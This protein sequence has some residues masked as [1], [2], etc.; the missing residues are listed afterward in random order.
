MMMGQLSHDPSFQESVTA[1]WLCESC[2]CTGSREHVQLLGIVTFFE[3]SR[4]DIT[5][6]Q[7][8]ETAFHLFIVLYSLTSSQVQPDVPPQRSIN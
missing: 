2:I 6:L 5:S 4:D 1:L 7:K 8:C 3:F